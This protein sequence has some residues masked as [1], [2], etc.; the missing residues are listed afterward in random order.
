LASFENKFD[1][2]LDMGCFHS[3]TPSKR[4]AY[5][6]KIDQLLADTGTLLLYLFF[7]STNGSYCPGVTDEDIRFITQTLRMIERKDG[8]E[9]GIHPSA[10]L[11]LQ[12]NR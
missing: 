4:P 11:T 9:R 5:V 7:T 2:I 1:L 6:L 10:W 8:T 12:R 3:L